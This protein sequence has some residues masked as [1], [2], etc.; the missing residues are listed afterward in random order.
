[1]NSRYSQHT[2][3][4]GQ[5]EAAMNGKKAEP[6]VWQ[7]A[8][9]QLSLQGQKS[10]HF[11]QV[12]DIEITGDRATLSVTNQTA[13]E[14][15]KHRN[16]LIE[17]TLADVLGR[18]VAVEFVV[19]ESELREVEAVEVDETLDDSADESQD[20]YVKI[21]DKR[22]PKRLYIDNVFFL[23]GYARKVGP[24]GVAIYAAL[25]MHAGNDTQVAWPS[26]NRLA[27][28]TNMSRRQAINKVKELEKLGIVQVEKRKAGKVND[29]NV[30]VLLDD[31]EWKN[32][33]T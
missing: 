16:G 15:L 7:I 20:E 24:Y 6:D 5:T 17:R 22:K 9:E 14:V 21:R 8:L 23:R 4:S 28:L 13:I 27:L 31:S 3:L 18:P 12:T 10:P 19:A 2:A 29:T 11:G 30:V 26:Y 1:M 33:N 32:I 25:P